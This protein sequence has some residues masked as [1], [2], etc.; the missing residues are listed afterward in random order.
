[1]P[2]CTISASAAT[3]ETTTALPLAID[4]NGLIGEIISQTG[5]GSRGNGATS[6]SERYAGTSSCGTR[7]VNVTTSSTR[8]R[9]ARACSRA[10]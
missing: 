7:P 3:D 6:K 9:S 5:S 10:S 1:M 8:S 4:S 2:S